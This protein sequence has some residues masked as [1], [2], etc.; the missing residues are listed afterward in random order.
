MEFKETTKETAI[1][2]ERGKEMPSHGKAYIEHTTGRILMTELTTQDT[3][4]SATIYVTY[5][6]EP[7]LPILVPQEMREIYTMART[8][9]RID[10]RA[11]YGKFR[12][13]QVT[14]TEKP[15]P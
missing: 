5:K 12:Q 3:S 7:G 9:T 1:R 4:L 11:K 10:G 13:F 14:T 6:A 2:G 15:K 8:D